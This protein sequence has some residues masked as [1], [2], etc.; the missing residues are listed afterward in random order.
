MEPS[1][2]KR[3]REDLG[4]TRRELAE[5]LRLS[6]HSGNRTVLNWESGRYPIPGLASLA[7]EL[8]YE[9]EMQMRAMAKM[10]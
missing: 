6:P 8:Y 9:K 4:M 1:D 10:L 2:I 3:M 5:E 7:L